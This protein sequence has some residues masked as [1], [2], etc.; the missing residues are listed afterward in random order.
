ME[1][2]ETYELRR[3]DLK[4]AVVI[5]GFPSVGLVSSIV[6]NYLI[7]MLDL[8]QIGVMDSFYFPT[9]SLIRDSEPHNPV[10]IYANEKEEGKTQV[11]VFISEF[12]PPPNIVKPVARSLLNWVMRQRCGLLVSP[13]G[14]ML[15][16]SEVEGDMSEEE[17]E[18]H[19]IAVYGVGSTESM[20]QLLR[21]N[22]I[23]PFQDGVIT[24]V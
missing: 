17:M 10:R 23:E 20:R 12:Q 7:S 15:D 21:S 5:D 11:A 18:E 3:M 2:I 9:V 8:E 4:D 24:G 14:L 16:T 13:E 22:G 1:E 19:R 6:A